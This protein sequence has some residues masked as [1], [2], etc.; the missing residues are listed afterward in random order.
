MSRP[1]LGLVVAIS[2][3]CVLAIEIAGTRILGPFYGVSIFLWS[4]L[5]AVTL[6]ALSLGYALGGRWA[7]RG[8]RAGR[9]ALVLAGA[10]LWLAF[11]PL[12]VHPLLKATEGLGLR[13]AVLV[14]ASALFFP[15]LTLLGMVSPYAIRL[16]ARSIDEV[17]RVAGDLYAISTLASVAGALATGFWLIPSVGV[18]GLTLG[19]A[20]SLLVAAAL[21]LAGTRPRTG[22]TAGLSLLLALAGGS[23]FVLARL[24]APAPAPA[25]GAA[26]GSPA[27][28]V[29]RE[30][31]PYAEI[32]VVDAG[33]LRYLLIDGGAHTIVNRESDQTMHPYVIALELGHDLFAEPGR[34]LLLGLGGGSLARSYSRLGWYVDAVE[35]DSAVTQV[36]RT[37]FGLRPFHA[38]LRHADA[39]RFLATASRTWDLIVFDVYGSG[40][41][42]FHL[43]T[44]E[45]FALAKSRL[46]PGGVVALNVET[47]GWHHPLTHAVGRTLRT[48]F[49]HVLA[50]PNA[51]PPNQLGNVVILASDRPLEI[52]E[53]ALGDPVAALGDPYDHWRVV[54]RN[55]GWENRFEPGLKSGLVL[56]DDRNPADVWA[57]EINR[58][59]RRELHALFASSG[60]SW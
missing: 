55:H 33:P 27:R 6:A 43:V 49:A 37:E 9:L 19:V 10:G 17:G 50:L 44:Q 46:A 1:L 58:Q 45:A 18:R 2:G 52:S 21:V 48:S 54:T 24:P 5:I 42:P 34:M 35:I 8:P 25:P 36:A 12:A 57:E 38:T 11:V 16:S 14:T 15:P 13:A 60:L 53:E 3:A 41:I 29:V 28:L 22:S 31:S 39:R 20:G 23:G 59:A 40:S 4:A 30:E 47:V 26:D 32:R 7:D 56:T 51:E